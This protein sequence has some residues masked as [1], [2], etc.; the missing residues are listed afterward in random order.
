MTF[1]ISIIIDLLIQGS[2]I[3][4]YFFDAYNFAIIN[5]LNCLPA[6]FT[7]FL[8]LVLFSYAMLYHEYNYEKEEFIKVKKQIG[9]K[10]KIEKIYHNVTNTTLCILL[11]ITGHPILLVLSILTI[12]FTYSFYILLEKE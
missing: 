4:Y 5:V 8:V 1:F 3:L 10:S 6:L 7:L 11:L 9:K 12:L 2:L